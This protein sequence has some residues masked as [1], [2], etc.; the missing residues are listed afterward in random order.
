MKKNILI[1]T[2]SP[3]KNGNSEAMADAF[4][5]GA[6]EAGHEAVKF[7]AGTKKIAGCRVCDTCFTKGTAC[8]VRDDFAELE[9]LIE[10]ADVLVFCTPVYWF[11][12]T[13]QI[14]AAIDRMYAYDNHRPPIRECVLLSCAGDTDTR[15]FSGVTE[16]YKNIAW[17]L[18]WEDRGILTVPDVN[19]I[20]DIEKTDALRQAEDM[21][22]NI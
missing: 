12:M 21:G 1:L 13:A 17:Y 3:R 7:R 8:S 9:P 19:D 22:K 6:R 16:T 20:G 5:K 2:G 18:E 10:K 4:I 14:K 15:V 11:G